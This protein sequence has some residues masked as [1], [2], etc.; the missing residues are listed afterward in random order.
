MVG[1]MTDFCRDKCISLQR[2]I[3]GL[4]RTMGGI[5]LASFGLFVLIFSQIE[6]GQDPV[7]TETFRTV[8]DQGRDTAL[9]RGAAQK[10][11]CCLGA[12]SRLSLRTHIIVALSSSAELK[13]PTSGR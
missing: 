2:K 3:S 6:T 7:G 5:R 10:P 13:P 1:V 4:G 11:Q 9:R 8:A 12:G